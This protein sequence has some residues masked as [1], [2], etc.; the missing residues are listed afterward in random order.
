MKVRK[1]RERAPRGRGTVSLRADGRWEGKL[2]LGYDPTTGNRVRRVVYGR[3][4]EEADAKLAAL[5]TA[6]AKGEEPEIRPAEAKGTFGAVLTLW[7]ASIAAKRSPGTV[8]DYRGRIEG[9]IRPALGH[10]V[11]ARLTPDHIGGLLASLAARRTDGKPNPV[12]DRTRAK[13]YATISAVLRYA[14]RHEYLTRNTAE[15]VDAPT[16]K[17]KRRRPL[18]LEEVRNLLTAIDSHRYKTLIVTALLTGMREGELFALTRADV[19][20][21]RGSLYVQHS[22][23]NVNGK[24][25]LAP[26]KTDSS[27]R[28]IDLPPQALALLRAHLALDAP[29]TAFVF[30]DARGGPLRRSNFLRDTWYPLLDK[31]KLRRVTF[32]DLRHTCATLML[33]AG[34]GLEVVSRVLGH[35]DIRITAATYAHVSRGIRAGALDRLE[36][37]VTAPAKARRSSAKEKAVVT[38]G[39]R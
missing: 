10:I 12:G 8:A 18:S 28:A 7:L 11:L 5:K 38:G 33:Q 17:P 26:V 39:R 3:T 2:S 20:L 1:K 14:V 23:Q 19:D 21:E 37:A 31:A 13:V 6:I 25:E 30:T 4:A 35:A 22:L 16:Y 9:Y 34:E 29:S 32:H 27:R 24:P 36:Q 15:R